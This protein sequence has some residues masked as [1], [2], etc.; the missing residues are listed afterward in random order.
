MAD[1]R[2]APVAEVTPAAPGLRWFGE[3][4][5]MLAAMAVATYVSIKWKIGGFYSISAVATLFIFYVTWRAI[6]VLPKTHGQSGVQI[7]L[8]TI[9]WWVVPY[10]A[11]AAAIVGWNGAFKESFLN[12]NAKAVA[13]TIL[14]Q[15]WCSMYMGSRFRAA[16]RNHSTDEPPTAPPH[17]LDG[18]D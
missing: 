12:E 2:P 7:N 13:L 18:V 15:F 17:A 8:R 10:V 14:T 11:I 9:L 4:V 6:R 3:L 16:Y 1:E 5:L